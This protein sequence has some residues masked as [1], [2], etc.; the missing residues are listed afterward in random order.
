MKK[1]LGA[2]TIAIPTPVWIIGTYDK[3]HKANAMAVAWGGICCSKPPAV[4]ISLRKATHT[5]GA[6]ME[7]R[8]YTINIPSDKHLH[9]VDYFGIVS[10]RDTDKFADTGLT[11]AKS[12]VVD[13]PYIE[14]FP[15]VMEC[16][17]LQTVEIGMH[18][19]FIAEIANVRCDEAMLGDNGLPDL[20]KVRPL[21]YSPPNGAYF[22]TDVNFGKAYQLG[23]GF[24]KTAD[25]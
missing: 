11:A 14:E 6:I 1:S 5:Y 23:M 19:Q 18:T 2:K 8:A 3:A 4:T 22:G 13:A 7:R 9:E 10:G 24:K 21:V 16:K 15:L 20:A 17:L 12:D 25:S